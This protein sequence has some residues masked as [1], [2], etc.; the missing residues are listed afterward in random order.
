MNELITV[1]P[2]EPPPE[3]QHIT[4]RP[5]VH[6]SAAVV[7]DIARAAISTCDFVVGECAAIWCSKYQRGRTDADFAARVGM[8]E[9]EIQA[10]RC[11]WE[12]FGIPGTYQE[13][14]GLK[15]SHFRVLLNEPARLEMLQWSAENSATVKELK[16]YR[17]MQNGEDLTE[18]SDDDDNAPKNSDPL[19]CINA[20]PTGPASLESLDTE[21]RP[22]L[23]EYAATIDED[24]DPRETAPKT[25]A[26]STPY[27]PFRADTTK[28]EREPSAKLND[29]AN[30]LAK[31]FA[32][33]HAAAA[34]IQR[35][36]AGRFSPLL[37]E[38]LLVLA[39]DAHQNEP[40]VGLDAASI[41]ASIRRHQ[42]RKRDQ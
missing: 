7:V 40:P 11:V 30:R 6:D 27:S 10:R 19:N 24:R 21:N 41:A 13:F 31:L 23:A 15:F 37:H 33:L 39:E 32:A 25:S 1:P 4:V 17:R 38:D 3:P 14:P 8:T 22:T 42:Q 16:A 28:P 29:E 35:I 34:A 18:D 5:T 20:G 2:P 9:S 36:A 12:V 26:E